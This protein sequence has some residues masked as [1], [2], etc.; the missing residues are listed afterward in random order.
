MAAQYER[1]FDFTRRD[2]EFIR[3]LVGERTGIVLSDHKVDMVYGRLAR[4]L[5]QLK[6]SSFRD[7]LSRLESDD[8][9]ELVEFTNALTTNLTA[10]F[11]EPHHFDYLA[12]QALPALVR[13]RPDRRLR[14]WSAGCST[15]EEPYSIAVTLQEALP[16]ISR[17][18]VRILATDLDSS[19]VQKAHAGIYDG[20]RLNGIGDER[21]KRWFQR[22]HGSNAGKVR[23]SAQLQRLITFKQLNLMHQWPMK[24]PFDVLFC[25]NVIIYFNKDTQR[26]LFDRFADILADDGYLFVG[27]SE[28]LHKVTDR[29]QLIEKTVYRKVK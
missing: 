9:Q 6:L 23:V 1:E 2:F 20:T 12:Q 4:R 3:Q 29:F 22:G 7:Y 28:T 19:V 25:R 17:W 14:V 27:H 21:W 10:F 18:D 16:N 8:D 24:G 13:Q 26:I 5:R 11:R 15:G